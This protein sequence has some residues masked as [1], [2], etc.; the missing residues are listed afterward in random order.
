[1]M[2][3]LGMYLRLLGENGLRLM[4]QLIN[5]KYELGEWSKDFIE[6]TISALKMKPN[7]TKCSEH[8]TISLTPHIAKTVARLLHRKIERNIEEHLDQFRFR[9]GKETRDAIG[10]LRISKQTLRHR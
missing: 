4:K 2:I 3:Y 9:R 8:C 7:A 6:V 5:N 1:M 10:M